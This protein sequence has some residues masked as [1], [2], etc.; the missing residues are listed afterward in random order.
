ML[1]VYNKLE[2]KENM[3]NYDD[4]LFVVDCLVSMAY[5]RG[6]NNGY[7]KAYDDCKD[8]E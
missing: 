7:K 4:L 2:I 5:E 8:N 1:D 6:F 3:D